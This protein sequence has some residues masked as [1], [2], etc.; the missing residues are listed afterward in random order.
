[1]AWIHLDQGLI[2]C[3]LCRKRAAIP[4]L[5]VSVGTLEVSKH[6]ADGI[7]DVC[8]DVI[9]GTQYLTAKGAIPLAEDA[10][11]VAQKAGDE[12]FN[13]AQLAVQA[14]DK[15]TAEIIAAADAAL[16]AIQHGGDAVW[17]GAESALNAFVNAQKT[18]LLAAQAAIDDLV[19]CAEWLAYQ[20]ANAALDVAQHATHALDI[21]NKAL[22]V[23]QAGENGILNIAE[24][25]INAAMNLFNITKIELGGSMKAFL[26]A[27]G[28]EKH[29]VVTIEGV[30]AGKAIRYDN[31][32]LNLDNTTQFVHAIFLK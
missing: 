26:G 27:S 23:A 7:L 2:T 28:G 6:V 9:K 18:V 29:F 10:L 5:Y 30:I 15:A 22:D 11:A 20:T 12:G 4:A 32:E 16:D 1:M 31:V 24:D 14:A 8:E 19:N 25:V 21:V 13:A 17:R 3:G